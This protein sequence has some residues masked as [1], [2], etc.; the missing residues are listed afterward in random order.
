MMSPET[1]GVSDS[2]R[3][4]VQITYAHSGIANNIDIPQR[5]EE[6]RGPDREVSR[7]V[8]DRGTYAYRTRETTSSD[9]GIVRLKY[10]NGDKRRGNPWNQ[11]FSVTCT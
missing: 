4:S 2:R 6:G 1:T 3:S 8:H 7:G 5:P 9:R 11:G 10:L